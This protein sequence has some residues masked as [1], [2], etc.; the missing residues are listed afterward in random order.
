MSLD[1]IAKQTLSSIEKSL[2]GELSD[3]QR[4][5]IT[6]AIRQSLSDT[7]DHSGKRY[8]KVAK[9]YCEPDADLAHK[10]AD[11]IRRAN[12]ALKANLESLR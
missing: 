8:Q 1:K 10:I 12:V 4:K 5:A 6:D 11:E 7:L 2:G 9:A 3:E